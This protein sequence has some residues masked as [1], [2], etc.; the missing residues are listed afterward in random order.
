MKKL[1]MIG[2]LGLALSACAPR[3]KEVVKEVAPMQDGLITKQSAH[4]VDIT[5][6][7]LEA[8]VAK[9]GLKVFARINHQ[10]NAA[11]M[12][13]EMHAST[14]LIFGSPKIGVPLMNAS[15]TIGIDLPVKALAYAGKDGKVYLSYNDPAY[16]KLRHGLSGD[17][18]ALTKMSGAVGKF[19]THAISE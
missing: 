14:L 13:L 6:D 7:R 10:E 9:K 15:P 18:L 2:A 19:T 12:G 17:H 8:V 5:I 16:L 1:L 4:S 11:K 3:V